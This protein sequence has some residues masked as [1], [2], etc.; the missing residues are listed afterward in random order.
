MAQVAYTHLYLWGEVR[1][2]IKLLNNLLKRSTHY[3]KT[4]IILITQNLKAPHEA[5]SL[6]LPVGIGANFFL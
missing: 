1:G 6:I 5:L 4:N 3:C 2:L